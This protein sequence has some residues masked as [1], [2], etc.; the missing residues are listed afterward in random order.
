MSIG[1]DIIGIFDALVYIPFWI[2]VG[3]VFFIIH[4]VRQ[5]YKNKLRSKFVRRDGKLL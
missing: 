1:G 5:W 2:G 3:L 4:R